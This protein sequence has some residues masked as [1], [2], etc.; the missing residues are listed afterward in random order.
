MRALQDVRL[1]RS[2]MFVASSGHE[3]GHLGIDAYIA[4]RPGVVRN[5]AGWLHLGA[6]IGAATDLGN[7]LLQASDD[8]MD[9]ALSSALGAAGLSVA[10]RAPRGTVPAGE[11]EAVHTGS[12]RYVSAIGSN[13]LFHNPNDRGPEAIDPPAIARFS[14]AF[15]TMVRS[16][17]G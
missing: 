1:T 16:I 12:G 9:Q 5:A 3:L 10:R 4:R 14:A 8:E 7:N 6:S 2:V 13:A 17:A 15:L 11:A